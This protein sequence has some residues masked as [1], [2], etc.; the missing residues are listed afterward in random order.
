MDYDHRIEFVKKAAKQ[1]KDLSIQEQ[2]RLKPKIDALAIEPRPN[3][4]VKLVG[5][6]DLYRIIVGNY[7]IIYTIVDDL[8]LVLVVKI[9]H[10]R[11]VYR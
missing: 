5:E 10:R 6:K 11:D 8:L 9:A 2:Q 3:G 7:R 1:F 4:I